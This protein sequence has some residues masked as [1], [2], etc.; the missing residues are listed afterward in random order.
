MDLSL[1]LSQLFNGINLGLL[2]V[3]MATGLTIIMGT[4]GVVNFSHGILFTFGAYFAYSIAAK[5]GFWAALLLAPVLVGLIGMVVEMGL[6]QRVYGK[7]PLY[8]LLLTFGLAM[9]LEELV[10]IGW[11]TT[12]LPFSPPDFLN[13]FVDLKIMFYPLYRLAV[14]G[15][16]LLLI[17]ALWFFLERTTMGKIVRAGI[18]DSVMVGILGVNTKVLFTLVFGLGTFLAGLAGVLSAPM[19]GIMPTMGDNV[20]MP[21]FIVII[22]GGVGSFHGSVVGGLL[23]GIIV[24][25]CIQFVPAVAEL[26]M[27]LVMALVLLIRPRGLFGEEGLFE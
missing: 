3:L 8:S 16:I 7:D 11:G 20:V 5:I 19:S 15:V 17:A 13:S 22:L 24:A 9:S 14:F 25:M 2:Y 6:V 18:Q 4:M 10:R 1:L 23:L 27:Y 12:G 21:S 26:S